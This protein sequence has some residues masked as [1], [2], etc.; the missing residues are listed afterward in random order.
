MVTLGDSIRVRI[1][2][3]TNP[4]GP[5]ILGLQKAGQDEYGNAPILLLGRFSNWTHALLMTSD[6]A[7]RCQSD[8]GRVRDEV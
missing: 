2:R 5:E 4:T 3:A 1:Q 6:S 8:K 7:P